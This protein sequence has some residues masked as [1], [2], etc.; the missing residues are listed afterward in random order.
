MKNLIQEFR[1]HVI[2]KSSN[3]NFIHHKWFIEYHLNI[4][5]KIAMEL[6]NIYKDADKNLVEILVWLHDYG[7]MIDFDNQNEVTLIE[8]RK[9]LLEIGF[10]NEFTGKA[11]S[12][13]KI[14]DS[15]LKIDINQAP[16]EVK[17]I[18]SADG[19]SHFVGPF[20]SLWWHEN[21]DKDF[22]DLMQDNINKIEKDWNKK[23]VLPEV[24]EAF[25]DRY[26]FLLEAGGHIP[27]KFLN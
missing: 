11:I 19:A 10:S 16:I 3:P 5:E 12:Y 18:S 15:K 14:I 1:K 24:R 2:Q 6:C 26:N 9:K 13:A 22:K 7:K 8:G 21:S 25:Q 27:P 20:L 17:I 23:I 4:V